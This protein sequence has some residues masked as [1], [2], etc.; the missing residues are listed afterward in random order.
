MPK[1]QNSPC[2]V[3]D[4]TSFNIDLDLC[5]SL[6]KSNCKKWAFQLEQCPTTHRQHLQGRFS[7]K[8]KQ[9]LSQIRSVFE[10][11]HLSITSTEN[12]DNQF[13]VLKEQTR[14]SGPF[15]DTDPVVPAH[16]L[17]R[18]WYPW[19]Q[20]I[21]DAATVYDENKINCVV[22]NAGLNGKSLIS[23]FI[24]AS[25]LGSLIPCVNSSKDI[26]R[27]VM[28]K[29]KKP[30]YVIDIPRAINH[31]NFQ[32]LWAGIETVKSGYAYDDRYSFK[33]EFFA[34][35]QIWVFSNDVPP[36]RFITKERWN[37]WKIDSQ[38]QDFLAL[39]L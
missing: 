37:L 31:T 30:L 24:A 10:G 20:R 3:W 14:I 11:W 13:Y 39:T 28:N 26:M 34:R 12:R 35:P 16:L 15:A 2:C 6:L 19:Q 5:K 8:Q 38:T 32:E 4:F 9:R 23:H 18:T 7:L 17:D 21:I 22:D 36:I 29:P 1:I 27:L 33:E 25:G